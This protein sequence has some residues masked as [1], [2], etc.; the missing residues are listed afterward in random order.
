MAGVR[1]SHGTGVLLLALL[2]GASLMQ[3]GHAQREGAGGRFESVFLDTDA[4]ASK[5]LGAARDL[6]AARQWNDGIDLIRQI[7]EEHGDHLVSITQGRYVNVHTFCDIL[8][9]SMPEEG[10][11]LYRARVDPQARRWFETAKADRDQEGLRKI[12]RRAYLSSYGDDALYLLGQLAWERGNLS[13]ARSYWE[14]LLPADPAPEEGQLPAILRFPAT[15]IEPAQVRARLVLCSLLQGQ[16]ARGERDLAAF[17]TLHPQAAGTIAGRKGNLADILEA[18]AA[19]A[20]MAAPPGDDEQPRTFAGN[21][22]RNFVQPQ[23]IDV[24]GMQWSVPLKPVRFERPARINDPFERFQFLERPE[25]GGTALPREVLSYYPVVFD[26]LVL[27]C[28]DSAVYARELL[29]AEG[30]RPAWGDDA[31]IYQLPPEQVAPAGSDRRVGLP[32]FTV[33]V[34]SGRLYARLGSR[35]ARSRQRALSGATGVLVCLDLHRQGDLAWSVKADEFDADGG[36]WLFDG[37]PLA[38][39]E[40]VYVALR[41]KEPQLQLN[42]ACFEA[43]TGKLVWNQKICV[44]LEAFG[45]DIEDIQHQLLTLADGRLYYGTNLGAVAALETR[46]GSLCWI[47]TYAR[48]DSESASALTRRQTHGPNPCVY[49]DGQVFVA[50]TDS[51]HLLA[52]DAETG[53][54][55]WDRELKG[56]VH[57]LV[58]VDDGKLIAA[59][60]LLYA[61]EA[62]TGHTAWVRGRTDPEAATCGRCALAGGLVYW[63]RKEEILLVETAT[64][65]NRRAVDLAAQHGLRGGGNIALAEGMLLLAQSDRLA[66]FSEFGSLRKER[67]DRLTRQPDDP[68]GHYDL[69]LLAEAMRQPDAAIAA[70]TRA[71]EL[72]GPADQVG[73]RPLK[74]R[75]T[76][77]LSR[78]L[79]RLGNEALAAKNWNDAVL[80]L[81]Q[82]A[83]IAPSPAEQ[84]EIRIALARTHEQ[85]GAP[86]EAVAAWQSLL[87]LP[88]ETDAN[89]ALQR[90]SMNRLAQ[91]AIDRLIAEHG[92]SIYASIEAA[93]GKSLADTLAR[94]DLAA[95][96]SLLARYPNALVREEAALQLANLQRAGG[97]RYAADRTYKDLLDGKSRGGN[98]AVALVGL[99]QI[100]ESWEAWRSAARWWRQLYDHHADLRVIVDGM[101]RLVH[102]LVPERLARIEHRTGH[103][104]A[105]PGHFAPLTRRWQRKLPL[106]SVVLVPEGASPADELDCV[107][108]AGPELICRNPAD[109]SERWQLALPERPH[110][111]GFVAD[112]L[113]L[114]ADS[115]VTGVAPESGRLLWQRTFRTGANSVSAAPVSYRAAGER[116]FCHTALGV[117]SLVPETGATAWRY[118]PARGLL[119]PR[120]YCGG[121]LV[122]VQRIAPDQLDVL[123]AMDGTLAAESAGPHEPWRNDPVPLPADR[124]LGVLDGAKPPSVVQLPGGNRLCAYEG[125]VSNAHAPPDLLAGEAAL[126][127]V[128]DGSTLAR[129]DPHT[130]RKIWTCRAGVAPL[131]NPRVSACLDNERLFVA[132]AGILRG[133]DLA[134][135]RLLWERHLGPSGLWRVQRAGRWLAAAPVSAT[136]NF[137]AILCDPQSGEIVERLHGEGP[138]ESVQIHF[139]AGQALLASDRGLVGF[140]PLAIAAE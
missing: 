67:E 52:F 17:R 76:R 129:F 102:D 111:A 44:G 41:R 33:S 61:F 77:R 34:D 110:W 106:G 56:N 59:G 8:L 83:E 123:D 93:A 42:V 26:N 27:Y 81:T 18:Q 19:L 134:D 85:R 31:A 99:A 6:L 97:D 103:A 64:G 29:S 14:Q 35:G 55:Q 132:T 1:A 24:G 51:D 12:V 53:L 22:Q 96:A 78:L 57:Q 138:A 75:A 73:G 36:P 50:P 117:S 20:A 122:V 62:E 133:I 118:A 70:Y 80:R 5:K 90:P 9:S 127:A 115:S 109:G 39:G 58:G 137:R 21:A 95:T 49:H 16:I 15:D 108:I 54:V 38:S 2:F 89:R 79:M 74:E 37:P 46:D 43:E 91:S 140:C 7:S 82:A 87:E 45:P 92:R 125:P 113:V 126:V 30:G 107:L 135:G 101:P 66:V 32:R 112:V 98:H 119:Q 10:L 71:R 63:P 69:A 86:E 124:L 128:V 25:R 40:Y 84:T 104:S 131:F 72:A 130:G 47:S 120:W 4:T 68:R 136:A 105:D 13:L 23:A 114:G 3:I 48:S 139:Q 121:N 94:H 116:L 11:A 65:E 100:A 88:E 28:D 60:D